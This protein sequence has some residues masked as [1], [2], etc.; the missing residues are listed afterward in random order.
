MPGR[1]VMELLEALLDLVDAV[2]TAAGIVV[3][4]YTWVAPPRPTL[5]PPRRLSEPD[6][7]ARF[8]RTAT[9]ATPGDTPA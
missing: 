1:L 3:F 2:S 6:E 9:I 5:P 7:L 8:L 4:W